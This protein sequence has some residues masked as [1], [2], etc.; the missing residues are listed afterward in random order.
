MPRHVAV[1]HSI[2][3]HVLLARAVG[4]AAE[5]ANGATRVSFWISFLLLSIY[6]G[7]SRKP[8]SWPL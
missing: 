3:Y 2:E 8:R 7:V 5:N 4:T 6:R 1:V